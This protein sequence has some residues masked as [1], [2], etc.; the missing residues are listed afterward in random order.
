MALTIQSVLVPKG[1]E[2]SQN[3]LIVGTAPVSR[4]GE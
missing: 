2:E 4:V 1:K 3:L